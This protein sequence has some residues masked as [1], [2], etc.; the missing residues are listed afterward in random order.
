MMDHKLWGEINP[1]LPRM[2]CLWCFITAVEAIRQLSILLKVIHSFFKSSQCISDECFVSKKSS[3]IRTSARTM[4]SPEVWL[5]R[6][7]LLSS[8]N[9]WKHLVT[10]KYFLMVL[11][12]FHLPDT[13]PPLHWH[14]TAQHLTSTIPEKENI[15]YQTCTEIFYNIIA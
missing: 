2:L 1:S 15:L 3:V 14:P 11:D 6:D 9:S 13:L 8:L 4:N 5:K 12:Q 10:C 7:P